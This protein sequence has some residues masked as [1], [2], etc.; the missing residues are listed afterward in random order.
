M[1]A[2]RNKFGVPIT[3]N[4]Y[5]KGGSFSQRGFRDDLQIGAILSQHRY[6]RAC[7]FDIHGITAEHFRDMVK[8]NELTN[9]LKYITRIE[10]GVPWVHLDCAGI[11][12][13]KIVFFN[14]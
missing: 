14:S 4:N 5:Y 1:D 2:L 6:G 13:E 10:E 8:N 7:D 11:N 9:E 12:S 3:V